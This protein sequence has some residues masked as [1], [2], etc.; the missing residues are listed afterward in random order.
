MNISAESCGLYL[1]TVRLLIM[2]LTLKKLKG[3]Q[4]DLPC[5]FSKNVSSRKRVKHCFFVAFN[6]ISIEIF[7][8]NFFEIPQVVMIDIKI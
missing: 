4:F 1:F 8:K 5:G 2:F 7:P 6:I 3:S